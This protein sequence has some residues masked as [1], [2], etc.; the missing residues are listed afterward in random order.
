MKATIFRDP[1]E[2]LFD[3]SRFVLIGGLVEVFA[4]LQPW[5]E[6]GWGG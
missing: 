3:V 4:E 1:F 2:S 6:G 5:Q